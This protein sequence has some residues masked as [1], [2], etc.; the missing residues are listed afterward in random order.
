MGPLGFLVF[1]VIWT[2][3]CVV[4]VSALERILEVFGYRAQPVDEEAGEAAAQ[5]AE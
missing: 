1:A 2:G 3:I 5:P 4:I